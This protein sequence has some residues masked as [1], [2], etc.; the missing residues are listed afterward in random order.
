[1]N[2][3]EAARPSVKRRLTALLLG[4]GITF[5]P[6]LH[7]CAGVDVATYADKTPRLD[8]AGYFN[9]LIDGQGIV[10]DR[11]GKILRRFTV[12]IRGTWNGDSGTLDED[13]IYDDGERQQRVWR[14]RR[15]AQGR[16][17]GTAGDVVGS[18]TGLAAGPALN[19]RYT[20]AVP[21]DG[22][23]WHLD[24]DDWMVLIDEHRMLNRATMS[25][26]GFRVGEVTLSFQ[27]RSGS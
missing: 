10:Q 17:T 6:A 24:F 25:K 9:G 4:A 13:F 5:L 12:L 11:S 18:A 27:K 20:L 23:V 2:R 19:W 3:T 16:Y 26:F 22:R 21:V 7:G 1:M 8:L 14:I 15:D